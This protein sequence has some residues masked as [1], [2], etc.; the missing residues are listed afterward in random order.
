MPTAWEREQER[1]RKVRYLAEREAETRRCNELIDRQIVRLNSILSAGL[2]RSA[3]LNHQARKRPMPVFDPGGL[4]L[5]TPEPVVNIH[6][7][8]AGV[9]E[10]R[11]V[12]EV[13]GWV[14]RDGGRYQ[15]L[16]AYALGG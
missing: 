7:L 11:R 6:V 4:D 16:L 5:P 14:V 9:L 2:S 13:G 1:E 12:G 15:S 3:P 10:S 8:A